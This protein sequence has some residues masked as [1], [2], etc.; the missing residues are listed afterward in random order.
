MIGQ[1]AHKTASQ[2]MPKARRFY[3]IGC[4]SAERRANFEV[5][6]LDVL[7]AGAL[8][9]YPPEGRR[10]FPAYREKP[11]VVIGKRKNAYPP[12]DIER[13]H[14]Y[15]L[16][17]DRLKVL[18]ESINPQAFAF[19]ACD[20]KLRDESTG[21]VYW[22][23]DVVRVLEAFGESSLEDIRRYRERTGLKYRGFLR[24]KT[25]V[26]NEAIIG[27]SHV[28]RTPY[29][30]MDVFCDQ[31]LKDACKEAGIKGMRFSECLHKSKSVVRP[32]LVPN[33]QAESR[34]TPLKELSAKI[35]TLGDHAKAAS[36]A[37]AARSALRM[38]PLLER[39]SWDKPLPKR[40]RAALGRPR[41]PNS[42]IVLG[43]F[44]SAATAWVSARFPAYG[45]SDRFHEIKYSARMAGGAEDAGNTP[46]SFAPAATHMAMMAAIAAFSDRLPQNAMGEARIREYAAQFAGQTTTIAAVG[47]AYAY[48]LQ[49]ME[50]FQASRGLPETAN[51]ELSA[52]G[53]VILDAAWE[54]V[55]QLEN[56]SGKGQSLLMRPLWL[57]PAPPYVRDDWRNLSARLLGRDDEHWAV[58]IDWYE[59]R[60]A[61]GSELSETHEIARVSLSNEVWAEGAAV[62]NSSIARLVV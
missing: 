21:P 46:A 40:M 16:I 44:R 50:R 14:S 39:L 13:F 11:R 7:R 19:Q 36:L 48:D 30:F 8:A 38:I 32:P 60:L 43:S 45:M 51:R 20:V 3:I 23:C 1:S 6:N 42:A 22:L 31:N 17:S 61:G 34:S 29:S 15:W 12:R 56:D 49:A 58:W 9:L 55:R 25:L 4:S 5:E 27:D 26:F 33:T 54:D 57:T 10:G 47:F 24:D 53:R 35:L 28:F 18:F 2:R 62:A 37:I 59:A 52:A 41:M